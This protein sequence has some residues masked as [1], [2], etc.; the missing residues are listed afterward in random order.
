M[1]VPAVTMPPLNR[2]AQDTLNPHWGTHPMRAPHRG[3][4]FSAFSTRRKNFSPARCSR[5]SMKKKVKNR[6]GKRIR[7]SS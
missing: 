2:W 4:V 5:Y 1:R 3:P 6:M 7:Q